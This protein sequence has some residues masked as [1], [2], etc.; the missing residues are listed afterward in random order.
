MKTKMMGFQSPWYCNDW[1]FSEADS[2]TS[3]PRT[4]ESNVIEESNEQHSVGE[5]ENTDDESSDNEDSASKYDSGDDEGNGAEGV[6]EESSADHNAAETVLTEDINA[7]IDNVVIDELA[8]KDEESVASSIST[9][10]YDEKY[11]DPDWERGHHQK[12]Q[13]GRVSC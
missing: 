13:M 12:E 4:A 7:S 11:R 2:H 6:H 5:K 10:S 1:H 9:R 8:N 3:R